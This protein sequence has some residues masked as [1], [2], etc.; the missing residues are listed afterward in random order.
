MRRRSWRK[1]T[2]SLPSSNARRPGTSSFSFRAGFF[3]WGGIVG[4][5]GWEGLRLG[6]IDGIGEAFVDFQRAV[7]DLKRRG[8]V[9]GVVSKN[10][11]SIALE[12][13]RKHPEMVLREE[14]FVGW[15]INWTDK[16]R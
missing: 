10:E 7:K 11:E 16:A 14:E 15:K 6:G 8:I 13:I 3:L 4:G 12:A 5:L 2:P 1:S 9:L